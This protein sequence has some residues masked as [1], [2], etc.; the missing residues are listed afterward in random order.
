[1][2]FNGTNIGKNRSQTISISNFYT[3]HVRLVAQQQLAICQ[4]HGTPVL[5]A[6][7][8]H[9][10]IAIVALLLYQQVS[11]GYLLVACGVWLYQRLKLKFC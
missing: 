5:H 9:E 2:L 7:A 11:L 4:R 3:N 10:L 6:E 8:R 1:M